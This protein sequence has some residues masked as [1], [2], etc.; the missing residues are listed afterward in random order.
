MFNKKDFSKRLLGKFLSCKRKIKNYIFLKI[1]RF[2]LANFPLVY[3]P[4]ENI[5]KSKMLEIDMNETKSSKQSLSKE[6][7][8]TIIGY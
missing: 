2:F 6:S 5:V 3:D 8:R 1:Y 4:D 7:K